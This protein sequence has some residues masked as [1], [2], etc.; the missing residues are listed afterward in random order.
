MCDV[1]LDPFTNHGHD[2]ILQD[3]YVLNDETIKVLIQQALYMRKMV[4][5]L[6]LHLT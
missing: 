3:D 6:L 1:A 5:I 4:V 2:G